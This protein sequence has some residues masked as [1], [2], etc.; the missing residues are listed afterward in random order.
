MA[1]GTIRQNGFGAEPVDSFLG[2][3]TG[4]RFTS[5]R[6]CRVE[7]PFQRISLSHQPFSLVG[8]R[9]AVF[10]RVSDS[11]NMVPRSICRHT[12]IGGLL[13]T[14]PAFSYAQSIPSGWLRGPSVLYLAVTAGVTESVVYVSLTWL[15]WE[16]LFGPGKKR[17][18]FAWLSSAIFASVHWESGFHNVVAA[19]IFGLV[20]CGL[21]LK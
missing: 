8:G 5:C 6:L 18:L 3:D 10:C 21:Y 7:R 2:G 15:V 4:R 16:R 1:L 9:C 14:G 13:T 12:V 20:A 19:L 17:A 11:G